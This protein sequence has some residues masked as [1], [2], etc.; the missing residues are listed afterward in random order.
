MTLHIEEQAEFEG[1]GGQMIVGT[2]V[3][4]TAWSGGTLDL[5][6][7]VYVK[8]GTLRLYRWQMIDALDKATVERIEEGVAEELILSAFPA[9]DAADRAWDMG[10]AAE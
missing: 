5:C 1:D 4:S 8:I 10:W 2:A 3:Y 9:G 6:E 7:L